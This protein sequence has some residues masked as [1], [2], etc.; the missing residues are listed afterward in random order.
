MAH[1][2]SQNLVLVKLSKNKVRCTLNFEIS[3]GKRKY[4]D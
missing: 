3:F 2:F 4:V 1:D